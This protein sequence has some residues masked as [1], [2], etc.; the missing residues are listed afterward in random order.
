MTTTHRHLLALASFALLCLAPATLSAHTQGEGALGLSIDGEGQVKVLMQLSD[1]DVMEL[2]GRVDPDEGATLIE[3]GPLTEGLKGSVPDWIGLKGDGEPCPLAFSRVSRK[4][5]KG[6]DVEAEAD[7]GALPTRLEI[8]WRAGAATRLKLKAI[9]AISAPE[10]VAHTLVLTPDD[11]VQTLKISEP[12]L[13][14][15]VTTF[16][17]LGA[18][19]ILI[20]WDHLAFLLALILGCRT[21]RRL[22]MIVTSFTLAH[23]VTL[24]LG[25][26]GVVVISGDIVEPVIALS[27][28]AAA[29]MALTSARKDKLSHP[30]S[31]VGEGPVWPELSLCFSFG[32]IHGL[33]FASMLAAALDSVEGPIAP[34]LGFNLGVEMGQVLCVALAFPVLT[35]IGRQSYGKKVIVG[36]LI[37]LVALGVGVTIARVI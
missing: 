21:W 10:G 13:F 19:H 28:A 5:M 23:S 35:S 6:V 30:G 14:D 37:G 27:I 2:I 4:G 11:P 22:L 17:F 15:T 9:A 18:E 31:E 24:A 1:E 26:L 34:L 25:A 16:L 8:H 32:L 12:A 3:E 20:G 7:C 29:A 33:G 36:L